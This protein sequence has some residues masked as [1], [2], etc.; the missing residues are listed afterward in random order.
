MY[1]R[2]LYAIIAAVR[3]WRQYLLGRPFT[4]LTDHKS[5]RELMSQVIQTPEQHYYLSKLLG[6]DYTIQYKAGATNVVADALSRR[7]PDSGQ[8]LFLSVPQMDFMRDIQQTLE[9]DPSSQELVRN[10]KANPSAYPQFS[11]ITGIP[12]HT[13]WWPSGDSQDHTSSR[14]KLLLAG[15]EARC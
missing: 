13:T 1:V 10:I 7:P 12:C 2:E 3:K 6:F 15:N 8:L 11:L 5:L 4:I 9:D 14:I